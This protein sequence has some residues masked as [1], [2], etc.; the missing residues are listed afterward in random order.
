MALHVPIDLD[1]RFI[2]RC[3]E[4]DPL[5]RTPIADPVLSGLSSAV[6][7]AREQATSLAAYEAAALADKTQTPEANV[8]RIAAAAG[9]T[10]ER[11]AAQLDAA[12]TRAKAEIA[13][14]EKRT[15]APPPPKD[16]IALAMEA[17][18]RTR[19]ANM[20]P[21]QRGAAIAKAK[22]E[23]NET[24][25]AAVLRGPAI[26]TGLGASQLEGVRHHYR[27]RFHAADY[28]RLAR[29]TKAL[30][31]MEKSGRLFVGLVRSAADSQAAR[32][33]ATNK[34]LL[35]EAAAAHAREA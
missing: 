32:L 8:L 9:K 15:G 34:A 22:A 5:T 23:N 26:L 16:A 29:L 4:T 30:D 11:V 18:I 2:D 28:A 21:K 31:A 1:E 33:A 24:I 35:E 13:N 12:R 19:L 27:Q 6:K 20:T 3:A 14:I 17:E 25:I 10:G 7:L